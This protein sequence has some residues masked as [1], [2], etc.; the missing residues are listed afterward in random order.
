MAYYRTKRDYSGSVLDNYAQTLETIFHHDFLNNDVEK[1]Y[2]LLIK[3]E[4]RHKPIGYKEPA[5]DILDDSYRVSQM[6]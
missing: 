1:F 2:K 5:E 3:V 6:L 4:K